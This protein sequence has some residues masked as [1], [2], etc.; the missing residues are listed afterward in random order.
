MG[1][2]SSSALN[3]SFI[4]N[5]CIATIVTTY[6]EL[7]YWKKT[8]EN[9]TAWGKVNERGNNIFINWSIIFITNPEQLEPLK[10]AK[11]KQDLE[12]WTLIWLT[13]KNSA[14]NIL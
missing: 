10:R 4:K 5:V 2:I 7:H 14:L 11:K 1:S 9:V 3:F 12:D 6:Y 8:K 13:D